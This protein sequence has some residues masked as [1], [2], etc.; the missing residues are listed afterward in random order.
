MIPNLGHHLLQRELQ[1]RQRLARKV[2]A[3]GD[4]VESRKVSCGN[5]EIDILFGDGCNGSGIDKGEVVGISSGIMEGR[6][7]SL[8]LLAT[9]LLSCTE[10][11]S[12]MSGGMTPTK[13]VIIDS[14]G[15][16]PIPLLASILRTRIITARE[17]SPF[18]N[19]GISEAS[20][21]DRVSSRILTCLG[22]VSIC[23]VFD[24]EG[25]WEVFAEVGFVDSAQET[26]ACHETPGISGNQQNVDCEKAG[27]KG[28]SLPLTPREHDLPSNES[29]EGLEG[30]EILIIDNMKTL[31]SELMTRKEKS[32][33]T[34]VAQTLP[35]LA[36]LTKFYANN[37]C[38]T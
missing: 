19:P 22:M 7:I 16:F 17:S 18:H 23:R 29:K 2:S 6:I 34:P 8:N 28:S 10:T 1:Q 32:E 38:S 11:S 36:S 31:I 35:N 4:D 26:S 21:E 24:V 33:G 15:L 14:T 27:L 30:I 3:N 20:V 9:L 13:A 5:H 37:S 12:T 25:M